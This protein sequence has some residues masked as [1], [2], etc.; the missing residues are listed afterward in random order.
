MFG[1]INEIK[2][3]HLNVITETLIYYCLY[4]GLGIVLNLLY[5]TVTF[6]KRGIIGLTPLWT[7]VKH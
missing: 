5:M 4:N 6:D 2:K 7:K 3:Y 1:Y